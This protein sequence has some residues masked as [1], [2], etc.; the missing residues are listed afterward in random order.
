VVG[1]FLCVK[2]LYGSSLLSNRVIT[3]VEDAAGDE[4]DKSS[5]RK[6][7]EEGVDSNIKIAFVD[8]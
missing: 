2:S 1:E 6:G 4:A 8:F 5:R 3:P 7:C